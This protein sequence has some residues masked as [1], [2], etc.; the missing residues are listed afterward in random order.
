MSDAAA[1]FLRMSNAMNLKPAKVSI[2]LA[3]D[4]RSIIGGMTDE[5]FARML[6]NTLNANA[7][8]KIT[9]EKNA[10]LDATGQP[11]S[12]YTLKLTK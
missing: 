11:Q 7:A 10:Y 5:Q 12:E 1:R 3:Q 4:F 9:L 2:E 8:S 6:E